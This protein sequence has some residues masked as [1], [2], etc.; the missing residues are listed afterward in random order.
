MTVLNFK[1]QKGDVISRLIAEN[2]ELKEKVR[3]LEERLVADLAHFPM[4][5]KLNR[6]QTKFLWSL[7]TAPNGFRSDDTLQEVVRLFPSE[8]YQG[9]RE[10]IPV[11]ASQT[12]IKVAKYRI[13]IDRRPCLGY[14]ISKES[15]RRIREALHAERSEYA[16]A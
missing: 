11:L 8:E 15:Q 12:R 9:G 1:A 3:Q 6:Q 14:Q 16:A 13:S 5:W 7:Y 2:A 10:N 4:S